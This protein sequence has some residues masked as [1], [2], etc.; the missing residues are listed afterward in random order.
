[1]FLGSLVNHC[2][3]GIAFSNWVNFEL[4]ILITVRQSVWF[5]EY[6]YN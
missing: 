4:N 1:M 5:A 3:P 6:G 2:R